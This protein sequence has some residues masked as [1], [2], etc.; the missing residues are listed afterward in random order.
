MLN[1]DSE[2]AL[3]GT[4]SSAVATAWVDGNKA[5]FFKNLSSTNNGTVTLVANWV[6]NTPPA[7]SISST[8]TEK[9]TSQTLTGT[10]T[11]EQ[12]G[13]VAYYIGTK[14]NPTAS[15]F[16][17]IS[18]A[19]SYSN[20]INVSSASTIY[21]F[22]KDDYGNVC[23]ATSANTKEICSYTIKNMLVNI[24]MVRRC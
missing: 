12:G 21:A 5:T 17:A 23:T 22:A 15:D 1:G 14:S 19:S 3:T 18:N 4:S 11:D 8:T 7:C 20:S 2:T 10:F 9:S 24:R 6:D 13:I 16:I